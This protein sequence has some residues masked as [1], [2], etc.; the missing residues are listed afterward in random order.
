[1]DDKELQ[2][3]ME[4]QAQL[5]AMKQSVIDFEKSLNERFQKYLETHMGV[6]PSEP[7][8]MIELVAKARAK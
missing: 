1:M 8:S 6:T 2:Q 4:D 7:I 3:L 5:R